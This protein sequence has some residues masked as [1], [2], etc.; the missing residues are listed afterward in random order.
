MPDF[1]QDR[2]AI[3]VND[4]G[5]VLPAHVPLNALGRNFDLVFVVLAAAVALALRAPALGVLVGAAG[6]L[7]QRA[8]AVAGR[9]LIVRSAAPGSRLGLNFID[10]FA[11][12]WLLAAAIV[13]A[14]VAGGRRDGLAAALLI[15]ATYSVAFAVRIGR[16][17][18]EVDRQ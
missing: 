13:I 6:W 14:A 15:F 7:V 5:S 1:K 16:G 12:I 8:A 4:A 17:R 2:Q 11:R 3:G 9:R 10:A 18:P